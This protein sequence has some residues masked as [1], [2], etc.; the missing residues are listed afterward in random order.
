MELS[1]YS[2]C[3]PTL[4][5]EELIDAAADAGYAAIEWRISDAPLVGDRPHFLRHNRCAVRE[6]AAAIDAAC[7]ATRAAG[8]RVAALSPYIEPGDLDALRFFHDAAR[9]NG[10]PVVRLRGSWLDERGY[11][12]LAAQDRRFL[13]AA[14]RIADR[15]PV[16][17]AVET[18]QRTTA[19]SASAL[20]R[21][22][23]GLAPGA[24]G[25]IYDIGNFAVEGLEDPRIGVAILGA[26]IAGVHVKN[27]VFE[28]SQKAAPGWRVRW[29]ALDEGVIDVARFLRVLRDAGYDGPVSV[30]DFSDDVDD[31]AK[32]ARAARFLRPLLS[33]AATTDAAA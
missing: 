7:A 3:T 20:D 22:V 8:V 14:E 21:L 9:R 24:V 18:H 5:P 1:I 30:E 2:A 33:A 17:F 23:H 19:P 26:R 32:I 25:A 13:T 4:L 27:A 15:S 29:C 16:T 6:D 12:Q 28:P 31:I 10:V 11:A